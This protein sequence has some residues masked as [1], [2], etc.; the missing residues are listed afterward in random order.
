[1]SQHHW[2]PTSPIN[3]MSFDCDATLSTI[4]GINELAKYS[5]VAQDVQQLT[6]QAINETGLSPSL[7]DNRLNLLKPHLDDL[8]QL[9]QRYIDTLSQDLMSV[10]DI[11]HSLNKT[12]YILSAGMNPAVSILAEHLQV[13]TQNVFAV[14]LQFDEQGR[15]TNFDQH[16]PLTRNDGKK[17]ILQQLQQKH[18]RILHIGDGMN[19]TCAADAVE[20]F[21]GFGG[22]NFNPAVKALAHHYIDSKS[23]LPLLPL[24]LTQDEVDS[25]SKEQQRYVD[26]GIALLM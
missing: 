13:P 6:Q 16:T 19:D 20:R 25:L 18:H 12:L 24:S 1:M 4:E 9:G 11:F 17:D 5:P 10:I 14:N 26:Q 15:Y 23:L 2:Q 21:I 3:A 8:T 7:F 22:N